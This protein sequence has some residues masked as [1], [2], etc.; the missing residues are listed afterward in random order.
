MGVSGV[1][2]ENAWNR[3]GFL[4]SREHVANG[5]D[6]NEHDAGLCGVAGRTA[7]VSG[8]RVF[9]LAPLTQCEESLFVQNLCREK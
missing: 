4:V 8:A 3:H 2:R 9:P 6:K 7:G 5:W 1:A